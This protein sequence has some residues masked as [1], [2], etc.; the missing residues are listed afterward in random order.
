MSD[1]AIIVTGSAS[2][3]GRA[4]TAMLLDEA[5]AWPLLTSSR[6]GLRPNF[7]ANNNLLRFREMLQY[8]RLPKC[9]EIHP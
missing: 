8:G 6:R 3:I 1:G 9:G 4:C 5:L 2:G 7:P